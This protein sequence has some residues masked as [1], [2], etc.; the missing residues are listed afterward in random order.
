MILTEKVLGWRKYVRLWFVLN[1]YIQ[2]TMDA[3]GE[4]IPLREDMQEDLIIYHQLNE[5]HK[6]KLLRLCEKDYL[7]KYIDEASN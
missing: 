6:A 4:L 3:L 7:W 5:A 1:P 2:Q